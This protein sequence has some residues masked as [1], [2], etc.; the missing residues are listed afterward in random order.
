MI[1]SK[2]FIIY[3][4]IIL[5][6]NFPRLH[7]ENIVYKFNSFLLYDKQIYY[8]LNRFFLYSKRIVLRCGLKSNVLVKSY[9]LNI[10]FQSICL[11]YKYFK[12]YF[13]TLSI[14]PNLLRSITILRAPCNHKNSKEH[15]GKVIYK[16][17]ITFYIFNSY[18][19]NKFIVLHL[20]FLLKYLTTV[21][22]SK[23]YVYK[24]C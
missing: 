13:I 1:L 16:G 7:K 11:L 9:F 3:C 12:I 15:Y 4:N 14:L 5:I 17:L 23:E 8:F 19:Y 22:I 20:V 24:V 6:E 10:I 21:F 2:K 18:L